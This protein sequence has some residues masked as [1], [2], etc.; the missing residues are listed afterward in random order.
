[1]SLTCDYGHMRWS[2]KSTWLRIVALSAVF[3]LSPALVNALITDPLQGKTAL[4][5]I[6]FLVYPGAVLAFAI[7]D[8]IVEGFSLLW[9]IAPFVLFL[10]PMYIFFN[11]S[12]LIYG[13]AY[14]ILGLVASGLAS[15]LRSGRATT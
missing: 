5:T 15:L 7:W 1:M 6:L 12:A 2:T 9:A 11:D 3:F 4:I 8:G 13:V 10:A 14:S